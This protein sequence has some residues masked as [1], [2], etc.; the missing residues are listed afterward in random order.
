M[1]GLRK[2][3]S[4]L[5]S[6]AMIV[7]LLAAIGVITVSAD[8]AT[9]NAVLSSSQITIEKEIGNLETAAVEWTNTEAVDGYNV[10]VKPVGGTYT[11]IDDEL[12]RYYGSH[13][14]AD[15]VGLAA[16]TYMMKVAAVVGGTEAYSAETGELT[17]LP[18]IREG[19]A[20]DPNSTYYNSD[21][22]GAY[23]M[24]GTLKDGAQVL[25]ID[26]NNK[27]TVT[28]TVMVNGKPNVGTGIGEI[29]SLREKNSSETT[30]L[31]IRMIGKID[32]PNGVDDKVYLNIKSAENIT[33]EGIGTDSTAF[34]WSILLR[35]CNNV[36]VRNL[37]VMEFYDD[38]ISLD[39]KNYNCWVHNCDVFYG[40]D[41]GGDQK[42]GDGSL[43]VK[44]G[45]DYCTFSYNHF[46]DCGKTSLCGMKADNNQGYHMTYY[47]NWFDHCDSRMPRV[48]GDQVHVYN[49]YYDGISKYGV[50]ACTGSSIFVE[51][52]VFRNV[53][54]AMMISQQ[55]TDIA[56]GNTGT[57]SNEEG[58]IIK[59]FNN[60]YIEGDQTKPIVFYQDD[61][62]Q[63]D[64][65]KATTRDE[66]VPDTVKTY[67][68]G[69][70]YS[71]FDTAATMYDYNPLPLD[72]VVNTVQA[73]AGRVQGGDF[74]YEF[75]DTVDDA[76]YSRNTVLGDALAGYKTTLQ[77]TYTSAG[78]YPATSGAMPTDKPTEPT[79]DPNAP[80]A[81]PKPTATPAIQAYPNTWDFGLAPFTV[82]D[83][84]GTHP[85]TSRFPVSSTAGRYNITSSSITA[86]DFGGLSFKTSST[87]EA[88]YQASSK[89]FTDGYKSS[90]Q[91]KSGAAGSATDRAF[92]FNPVADGLVTVYAR[93]GSSTKSATLTIAQGTNKQ[94]L[95]LAATGSEPTELP[96][97]SMAVAAGTDVKIYS[98]SNTGYYCIKYEA[99]GDIPTPLP[100]ATSTPEPVNTP[101]AMPTEVP[102]PS[103]DYEIVS[104]IIDESGKLS[105]E[106]KSVSSTSTAKLI[107]AE[108]TA[109]NTL[110][111]MQTYDVAGSEISG[112]DY[113]LSNA[114]NTVKVMIWDNLDGL[115]PLAAAKEAAAS[116][117]S[118]SAPTAAPTSTPAVTPDPSG[119]AT[120]Y[121]FSTL[122]ALTLKNGAVSV[123]DGAMTLSTQGNENGAPVVQTVT[124]TDGLTFT[125]AIKCKKLT[126][127]IPLTAGQTVTVYYCG[128]DSGVTSA[129][130]LEMTVF[131]PS[132]AAVAVDENVS[133]RSGFAAY[134]VSYTA[135]TAGTYK[136]YDASTANNRTLVYG[137]TVK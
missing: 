47:G 107:V 104:A 28:F 81:T 3:V 45:S 100:T 18:H 33:F 54:H 39:T 34:G 19:F 8:E 61:P 88:Q 117:V 40:Q 111:N 1:T 68:G 130:D 50:G 31:A 115:T 2:T 125:G 59:E 116:G 76:D 137:V 9:G 21:G 30:P 124:S 110:A 25:Y 69:T 49:N 35:Q 120:L 36:E 60:E 70:S 23:K 12:V 79:F 84:T 136:I 53:T 24:D 13:Y 17:V 131:D 15:A 57:F 91:I 92:S 103:G 38:G 85:D 14:R 71:N 74:Y 83:S 87:L 10:Y 77:G 118:P 96:V 22:V 133:E 135:Q 86:A 90:W 7:S 126:I 121:D 128:S 20:F 73:Y 26:N 95:T 101:T 108:Y 51:N 89:T 97:L 55:G 48:R 122:E 6:V 43:D 82:T 41:R 29:L 52:N 46:W 66:V 42:K 62:V 132:G 114:D 58:G 5:L 129:K 105:V 106:L 72:Q 134:S 63:F 67:K 109:A 94:T 27:D 75:D 65:Y 11:K 99:G 44:S 98:D 123:F 102:A 93:S 112:L 127:E 4:W 32:I 80:T 119:E 78:T 16:G 64:A 37:A 113:T 56:G